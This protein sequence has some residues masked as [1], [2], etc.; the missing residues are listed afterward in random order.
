L[1]RAV[2]DLRIKGWL[3]LSQLK[4]AVERLG[5]PR[6]RPFIE[7]P[8]GPTRSEFEDAFLAFIAEFGLP[9][10]LINTVVLGRERDVVFPQHKLIVELDGWEFHGDEHAFRHD[11]ER[12]AEALK[13]GWATVRI[14]WD[15]LL[16]SPRREAER[17]QRIL[18]QRG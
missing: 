14:T 13:H 8:T 16:A 12:D 15:R 6:L 11:R 9:V 4:Q 10:P 5:A 3:K 17:F 7:R 2:N 18:G 1:R